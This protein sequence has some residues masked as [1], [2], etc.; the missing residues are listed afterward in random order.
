MP[1]QG[2]NRPAENNRLISCAMLMAVATLASACMQTT[3]STVNYRLFAIGDA[4]ITDSSIAMFSRA[5]GQPETRIQQLVS[6][7]ISEHGV[8]AP[9][10][11]EGIN[12]GRLVAQALARRI[13]LDSYNDVPAV[14][15]IVESM[16]QYAVPDT[17]ST[18]SLLVYDGDWE[19]EDSLRDWRDRHFAPWIACAAFLETNGCEPFK[20]NRPAPAGK[21]GD[22]VRPRVRPSIPISRS[23]RRAWAGTQLGKL[24]FLAMALK[25]TESTRTST[26]V[27]SSLTRTWCRDI[28][29]QT[30]WSCTCLPLPPFVDDRSRR[31]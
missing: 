31:P 5:L 13:L 30:E 9:A 25:S 14:V 17:A 7:Y 6:E 15:V 11:V 8:H 27:R 29:Q 24:T 3:P 19:D 2:S 22:A 12:H 20:M 23:A 26:S 18:C 4:F 10:I 1:S 28:D 21:Q 16:D